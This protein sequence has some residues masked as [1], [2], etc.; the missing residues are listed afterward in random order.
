SFDEA[1]GPGGVGEGLAALR[2]EGIADHIGVAG[3]A[4]G[5]LQRFIRTGGFG[6][7]VTPN[8]V[9]LGGRSGGGAVGGGGGAGRGGREGAAAGSWPGGRGTRASTGTGGPLT[10][11][12]AA[13]GGWS[14]CAQSTGF[15]CV[16]R[17][18]T[19]RCATRISARRS[20]GRRRSRT[21]RNWWGWRR[22]TCR[23]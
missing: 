19:R 17:R 4:G 3:G 7:V 14:S 21:W 22:R 23:T 2:D 1:M 16:P 13:S 11:C 8:P 20:S 9:Q 5:V 6:G 18:C 12:C 15:R 10:R